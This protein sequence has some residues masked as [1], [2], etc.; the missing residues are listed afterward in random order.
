MKRSLQ[1]LLAIVAVIAVAL[2]STGCRKLEARDNLNKGVTAFKN[3]K[4]AD[5]AEFFTRAVELDP[6][7]P[8]A[9]LYLATAYMSQYIPGADSPENVAHANN[10][11]THF[12]KV[13]D[14]EPKNATAIE[15]IASL[16]YMQ[17]QGSQKLE[18]KLKRLDTAAE[19]YKRL[20]E[21]EPGRKEAWYSLGV[22]AWAKWYPAWMEARN[23]AGMKPEEPGPLKDKKA[24][25]ELNAQYAEL[26][27][28][29]I[30]SLEKSLEID[31]EY[32]DAMAYMNLLIRERADLADDP[33]VYRKDTDTADMWM[34]KA[35][36]TRKIK[37]ERAPKTQGIVQEE[38]P[39]A[40]K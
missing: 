4:Y 30:K 18:D 25:A 33:G 17:A 40:A 16:Y 29:G 32:D 36:E 27:D 3:A 9:R 1:L 31:K 21:V 22:I 39:A 13:L 8:T 2:S 26:I 37:A 10:A 15:S 19:W 5:A 6:D 14:T 24:R 12:R 35:L 38:A 28:N 20:T 11:E 23:K 34:Q 7:F